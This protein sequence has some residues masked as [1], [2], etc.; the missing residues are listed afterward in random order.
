MIDV[1]E[2][3]VEQQLKI[4][5]KVCWFPVQRFLWLIPSHSLNYGKISALLLGMWGNLFS[6][7]EA[8]VLQQMSIY[9]GKRHN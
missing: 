1:M 2:V 7:I 8:S 3:E 4:V 9:S 5:N 6:H